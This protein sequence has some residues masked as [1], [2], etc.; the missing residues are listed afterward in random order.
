M[1]RKQEMLA[2]HVIRKRKAN[3]F[4]SK[5]EYEAEDHKQKNLKKKTKRK[6]K[7]IIF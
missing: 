1:K 3:N 2:D 5:V 4:F 6:I 7:N